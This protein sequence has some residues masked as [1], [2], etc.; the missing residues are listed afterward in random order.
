MLRAAENG[1][2]NPTCNGFFNYGLFQ[3]VNTLIPTEQL[4][5]TSSSLTWLDFNGQWQYS[6]AHTST[7]L[8][9]PSAA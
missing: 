5:L 4:N 2:A 8:Y 7:P 3:H 9:G 1:I 6:H